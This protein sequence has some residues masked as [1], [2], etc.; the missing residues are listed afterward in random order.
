[1]VVLTEWDKCLWGYA[2]NEWSRVEERLLAK[3]HSSGIMLDFR[4]MFIGSAQ[5]C[6][7]DKQG[8]VLIPPE[9]RESVHLTKEIVLVGDLN[10]FAIW[11]KDVWD[12]EKQSIK[13][14]MQKP[15]VRN[16]IAQLGL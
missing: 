15:E 10:H 2:L 8:R 9:L 6:S 5:E 13:N 14:E 7:L 4:G 11:P 12:L 16:E 1:M 3:S